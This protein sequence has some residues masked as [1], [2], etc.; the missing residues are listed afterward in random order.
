M[1]TKSIATP[2]E[3]VEFTVTEAVGATARTVFDTQPG[4][5]RGWVVASDPTLVSARKT[6]NE[7]RIAALTAKLLAD[8]DQ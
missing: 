1:A 6:A 7:K 2:A 5:V 8:L 4:V 3:S